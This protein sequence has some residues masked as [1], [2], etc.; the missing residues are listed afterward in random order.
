MGYY[1][2][3]HILNAYFDYLQCLIFYSRDRTNRLSPIT[4]IESV[5]V[6]WEMYLYHSTTSQ[7]PLLCNNQ[8]QNIVEQLTAGIRY[9]DLRIAHK[10]YDPSNE[11]YFTHVIY[12]HATVVVSTV[13]RWIRYLSLT[14][15]ILCILWFLNILFCRKPYRQLLHGLNLIPKKSS[16]WLVV[17]SKEWILNGMRNS[18]IL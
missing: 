15:L 14:F 17:T 9:F 2:G 13:S 1:S 10:Q 4:L 16:F 8:V 6:L 12:T 11:L 18:S 7:S 3:R 5:Y